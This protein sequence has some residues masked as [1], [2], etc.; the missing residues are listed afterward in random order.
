M[1]FNGVGITAMAG[2]VPRRVI[3]NLKYTE[4]F[5]L[6]MVKEVA[7]NALVNGKEFA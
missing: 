7:D 3:E 6:E 2:A 4:H 1:K 5:P